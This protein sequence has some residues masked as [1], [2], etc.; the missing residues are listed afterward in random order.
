ML[1][2]T[3]LASIPFYAKFSPGQHHEVYVTDGRFNYEWSKTPRNRS[4]YVAINN[5]ANIE[6][7]F[8]HHRYPTSWFVRV[9]LWFPFVSLSALALW[10][11]YCRRWGLFAPGCCSRCGYALRGL[12]ADSGGDPG[13]TCPEC[14]TL[15]DPIRPQNGL[16]LA[17]NGE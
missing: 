4:S 17:R 15:Q 11:V 9:P 10:L 14:G 8:D 2:C 1:A 7:M 13:V 5:T 12:Q 16:E 3:F 6:W